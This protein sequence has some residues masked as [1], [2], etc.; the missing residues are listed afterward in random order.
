[1][2]SKF[3]SVLK[4]RGVLFCAWLALVTAC[5]TTLPP[6]D[7]P[8]SPLGSTLVFF[9]GLAT[10]LLGISLAMYLV[11]SWRHFTAVT[12]RYEY[13]VCLA[14]DTL[15]GIPVLLVCLILPAVG[16]FT[17]VTHLVNL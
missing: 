12:E 1:M 11:D 13:A 5:G 4:R 8:L 9:S 14:M 2:T 17:L 6:G 15:I 7:V 10:V 16:A 3:Q